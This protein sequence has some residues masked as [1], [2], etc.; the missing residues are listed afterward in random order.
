MK[1]VLSQPISVSRFAAFAE[2]AW[3]QRRPELGILCRAATQSG[4]ILTPQL[5]QSVVPGV[6]EAGARNIIRSC[7]QLGLCSA[8]GLLSKLATSIQKDDEVP[9]PEQGVYRF[10]VAKHPVLG[11]RILAAERVS[12][13][14]EFWS[15]QPAALS[16]QPSCN[17]VFTSAIAPK[18][19]FILREFPSNHGQTV[20]FP[21]STQSR[22]RFTWQLDF[23]AQ[24]DWWVLEGELDTT[25]DPSTMTP[26]SHPGETDGLDLLALAKLWGQGPLSEYGSW[27]VNDQRLAVSLA[28]LDAREQD[29]FRKSFRLPKATVPNKGTYADVRLDDV[30]IGP[31]SQREA[32]DWAKGILLRRLKADVSYRSRTTL[33]AFLHKHVTDTPLSAFSIELPAH[34]ALLADTSKISPEVFWSVAAPVDLAPTPLEQHELNAVSTTTAGSDT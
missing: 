3:L 21:E 19:R 9:I 23:D 4:M 28:S 13:E 24:T 27:Q 18:E 34:Q 30:P 12:A 7:H 14:K 2:M 33:R 6:S 5:I 8:Q 31:Q 16:V 1:A 32:N 10:W 25:S 29:S 22:C 15:P 20:C 17:V 26:I 11:S